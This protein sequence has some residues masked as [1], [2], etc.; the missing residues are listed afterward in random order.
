MS[1]GGQQ[2]LLRETSA[3]RANPVYGPSLSQVVW[4]ALIGPVL[5]IFAS[6]SSVNIFIAQDIQV[7]GY[8]LP[9]RDEMIQ[10]CFASLIINSIGYCSIPFRTHGHLTASMTIKDAFVPM[11]LIASASITGMLETS[12]FAI[13]STFNMFGLAALFATVLFMIYKG[14]VLRDLLRQGTGKR[15]AGLLSFWMSSLLG[16]IYSQVDILVG[17]LFLQSSELGVYQ[18]VKRMINLISLPQVIANWA[19]VV[20]IGTAYALSCASTIQECCRLGLKLSIMPAIGLTLGLIFASP[21]LLEVYQIYPS[22]EI[23]ITTF[24]L[25]ASALTNL[26]FGVNFV[27]ASQC[28]MENTAIIARSVCVLFMTFVMVAVGYQLSP[29]LTAGI[30]LMGTA[31]ANAILW[32]RIKKTLGVDTSLLCLFHVTKTPHAAA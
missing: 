17:G 12:A 20:K 6:I 18:I 9:T 14:G 16:T 24:L 31:G 23:G 32:F 19:T 10:V 21:W 25:F 4:I 15:G 22:I 26:A 30:L 7:F 11:L 3:R 8:S 2:F 29:T 28:H 27:V 13:V 1:L 5:L